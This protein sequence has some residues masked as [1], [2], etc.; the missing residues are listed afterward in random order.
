[1]A[2]FRW[3]R[4]I[5]LDL[6][7]LNRMSLAVG[8]S[9]HM[10]VRQDLGHDVAVAQSNGHIPPLHYLPQV[11]F[12]EALQHQPR[13]AGR[14]VAGPHPCVPATVELVNAGAELQW[15]VVGKPEDDQPLAVGE[16][17]GGT[18]R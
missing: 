9:E 17:T 15:P 11:E 1:M 2:A 10:V 16:G 3:L 13:N 7:H 5:H 12:R 18:W 14:R 4:R 8:V 6:Q